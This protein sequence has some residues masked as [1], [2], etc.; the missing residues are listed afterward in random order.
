MMW[1]PMPQRHVI[2]ILGAVALVLGGAGCAPASGPPVPV[3]A[4]AAREAPVTWST[5]LDRDHALVGRIW[6]VRSA[7]FVDEAAVRAALHGY[8]LLGEKHDNPDHHALQ[9]RLL[10]AMVAAGRRPAVAFE[11]FDV[12]DQPALETSRREHPGDAASLARAVDWD[13]SGWPPWK[14]YAPIAQLALDARLPLLATGLPRAKMRAL[15]GHSAPA[16]A[17]AGAPVASALDEGVPLAPAEE[18]S[19]REELRESHCGHLPEARIGGMI[20]FQRARDAAM[21]AV[22]V[23]AAS[24]GHLDDG[25]LIA[26]TGH[27]RRDRGA[28]R[29][30][31]ARDPKRPITSIAFTEVEAGKSEPLAY[32][33]RWNATALPF[34]FVWFTPRANDDDPCAAF[35]Q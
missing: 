29:D 1:E 21:A 12:D 26:G 22:L 32:A 33:P 35:G 15:M 28:G 11:M 10:R 27:T 20:R 31:A 25:V 18:A 5:H 24:A 23:E 30:L 8:V 13:K 7:S 34:D 3:P 6:S 4:P 2:V 9:A 16:A 14:D 19:L 17:D